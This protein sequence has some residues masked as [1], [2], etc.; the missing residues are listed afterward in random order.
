MALIRKSHFGF[1][2]RFL[3]M[4]LL[5]LLSFGQ[6]NMAAADAGETSAGSKS[7]QAQAVPEAGKSQ[8]PL[9]KPNMDTP[10]LLAWAA[11]SAS[12]TM[13]FGYTD[14]QEHLKQSSRY[15]TKA[16]WE[17]FAAFMQR[18]RIIEDMTS[19]DRT[20]TAQLQSAP[21][22]TQEGAEDGKHHWLVKMPLDVTLVVTHKGSV[23]IKVPA[24]YLLTLRIERVAPPENPDGIRISRWTVT[25]NPAKPPTP[26][27]IT[28]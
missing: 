28:H 26:A 17:T 23:T 27:G 24:H 15:F 5:V 7:L 25:S 22:V 18:S 8:A 19:P 20:V 10:A 9:D 13:T 1:S 16:G 2:N 11:A 4:L 6:A 14:Y 21:I 12:E 3:L